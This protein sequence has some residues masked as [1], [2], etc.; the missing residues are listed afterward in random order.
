MRLFFLSRN[1]K[2]LGS[3]GNKA[4]T[5]IER[6]MEGMGIRHAS[7]PRTTCHGTLPHFFLTLLGMLVASFRL[8]KGDILVL[9]Y[10]LKKYFS[11]VCRM[12][13]WHGA[14][15]IVQIH[16]LGSFR[17]KALSVEKEIRR[18]NRADYIIAHND[19]MKQWLAD[20][21]CKARLGTLGIFDYLSDTRA[22]NTMSPTSPYHII[23]AGALNPRKNSFL[24]HWGE[25]I[26]HY[27]VKLYGSGFDRSQAQGADKFQSM[28]F[29][30]SD[31]LIATASGHF[32]LVWDGTSVDACTGDFGE[33]LKYNNPHKTSLYIRCCLPVVIWKEAALA[34]FVRDNGI[35]ICVSSLRE[36]DERLSSLTPKQYQAMKD[37]VCRMSQLLAQGHYFQSALHQALKSLGATPQTNKPL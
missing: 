10:P 5:D 32:G 11:F 8:G 19:S 30:Q 24:Y 16:D 3:A 21:G 1:Y 31:D 25:H 17:R 12:A 6:I 36:L 13:H 15:T 28:G 14:K 7:L 34:P 27:V 33:Y 23:Y 2:G 26:H 18:L 4:K 35:G 37:N 22:N 9:Q 29:V 20:H